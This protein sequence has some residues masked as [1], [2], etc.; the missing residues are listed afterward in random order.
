MLTGLVGNT[1]TLVEALTD[2]TW[3]SVSPIDPTRL[4]DIQDAVRNDIGFSVVSGDPYFGGKQ[5]AA[6][7][8]LSLIADEVNEPGLAVEYKNKFKSVLQGWLDGNP[9]L[10]ARFPAPPL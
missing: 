2:I 5:M 10:P 3:N 4:P 6:L 8:R 7:A 9:A 1:W